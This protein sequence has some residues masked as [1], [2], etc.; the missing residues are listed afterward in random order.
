MNNIY[1]FNFKEHASQ[2]A[3]DEVKLSDTICH[4]LN[5][6]K[7]SSEN[8]QYLALTNELKA[9]YFIGM[10]WIEWETDAE[11]KKGVIYV[12]PK[13]DNIP[14]EKLLWECLNHPVVCKHL[15]ECYEIFPDE[16]PIPVSDSIIDFVTPLLI[17][18]YLLRVQKIVKKGIMKGYVDVKTTLN[19]RIKGKVVVNDTIKHH[20]KKNSITQT[21]CSYQ[22]HTT[23]CLENR[24]LKAALLQTQKYIYRSMSDRTNIKDILHYNLIAFDE[25]TSESIN[26]VDFQ[27]VKN[28]AFYREYKKTLELAKLI[29]KTLGFSL[30]SDIS[31]KD[32]T[33][34]PFYINMPE[35]FERYCEVLLRRTYPEVLAGYGRYGKSETRSGSSKLRPDFIIPAENRIIDSKYKYWI[36][37]FND[38]NGLMQLCQY[39]R[40][41]PIL[42]KCNNGTAL[43]ILQFLYPLDNGA[44][45]IDFKTYI[46]QPIDGYKEIYKYPI[47]L[48]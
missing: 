46:N 43:P 7:F 34:P 45:Q 32:K 14:F 28:N 30:S 16:P 13:H 15:N 47:S 42:A 31:F 44:K 4:N 19:N 48:L 41:N 38:D 29:L 25:V 39:S 8:L 23:D 26:P 12:K 9:D 6:Y 3:S 5:D 36:E 11:K 17:T 20:L 10:R 33:I 40:Y 35:L 22:I 24:I 18:D 27:K 2:D 37:S 1:F 21:V